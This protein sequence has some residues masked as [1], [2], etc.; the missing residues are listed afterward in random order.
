MLI[1]PII[2]DSWLELLK[3]CFHCSH[4][5]KAGL[6]Q[7]SNYFENCRSEMLKKVNARWIFRVFVALFFFLS[8][9]F[10]FH[11]HS[12]IT[13]LQGKEEGISLTAHYHFHPLCRHLNISWAVTA[14]SS[15]LHIGSS[16][17]R[18]GNL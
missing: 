3:S 7:V 12:R 8:T 11:N 14:K 5:V 6:P 10:F 2:Y 17:T 4:C 13:G 15:L 18:T 16:R 9:W 1:V